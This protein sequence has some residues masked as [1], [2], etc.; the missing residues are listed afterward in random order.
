[1]K[2]ILVIDDEMAIGEV[3]DIA[4]TDEGYRVLH[5][6]DGREGLRTL[7]AETVDLVITDL[8]MPIVDGREVLRAIRGDARKS[9]IPV[10]LMS[11]AREIVAADSLGE[12]AFLQKPFNLKELSAQIYR[13]IGRP[14]T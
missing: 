12:D 6:A 5:A 7:D 2:T 10:I 11:A 3:I 14:E 13:L 9:N 1:M 4:M 8:M